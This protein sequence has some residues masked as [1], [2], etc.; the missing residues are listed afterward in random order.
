MYRTQFISSLIASWGSN[1]EQT[2]AQSG[3]EPTKNLLIFA[4]VEL[5]I[6]RGASRP[7]SL[8]RRRYP[9]LLQGHFA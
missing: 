1:T 9:Y 3:S 5:V 6:K 4:S 7:V 8:E 2:H